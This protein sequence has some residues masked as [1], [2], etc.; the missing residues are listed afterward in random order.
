MICADIGPAYPVGASPIKRQVVV[1]DMVV[2][3]SE[4]DE[5]L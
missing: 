3:H 4:A 2:H 1:K 5:E